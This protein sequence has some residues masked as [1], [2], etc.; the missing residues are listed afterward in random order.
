MENELYKK[1]YY[2]LFNAITDAVECKTKEQADFILKN[3]QIA[4]EDIYINYEE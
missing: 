1:M 3:A 4:T 2:H